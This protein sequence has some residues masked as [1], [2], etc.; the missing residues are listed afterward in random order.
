VKLGVVDATAAAA[1]CGRCPSPFSSLG[2]GLDAI[3]LRRRGANSIAGD[4][5]DSNSSLV[6]EEFGRRRCGTCQVQSTTVHGRTYTLTH[7]TRCRLPPGV[8]LTI[9][10]NTS[11]F[12][13]RN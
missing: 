10:F 12:V 4:R 7:L 6:L 8:V 11:L 2:D 5:D 9:H 1:T 13:A 3:Q